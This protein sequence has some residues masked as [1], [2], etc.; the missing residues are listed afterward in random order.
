[1]KLNEYIK[2]ANIVIVGEE[3]VCSHVNIGTSVN[4]QRTYR[5]VSKLRNSF[6]RDLFVPARAIFTALLQQWFSD[7]SKYSILTDSAR[8]ST[9]GN[10]A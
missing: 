9:W 10:Q 5:N 4:K 2:K 6:A 1:M 7:V 8:H 3:K